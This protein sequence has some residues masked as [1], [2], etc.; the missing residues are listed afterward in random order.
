MRDIISDKGQYIRTEF[1]YTAK[2]GR[3]TKIGSDMKELGV[4]VKMR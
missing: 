1:A 3:I 2:F 4:I